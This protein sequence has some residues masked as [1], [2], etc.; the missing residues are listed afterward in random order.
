MISWIRYQKLCHFIEPYHAPYNFEHRYWTSLLLLVRVIV[1]VVTAA[2]VSG[3]PQL[4]LLVI[5]ITFGSLLLQK[6]LLGSRVYKKWPT[7]IIE[8]IMYFNIVS[9]TAFTSYYHNTANFNI[10]K[11]I[12]HISVMFTRSFS[13][14]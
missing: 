10:Q 3:T 7:D 4:P 2:N 8:T 9:F 6:G 1:Y 13:S 5:N 12:A 11:A 14:W